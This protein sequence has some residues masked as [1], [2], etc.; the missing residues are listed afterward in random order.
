MYRA[1]L[2]VATAFVI[3][4]STT[5]ADVHRRTVSTTFSGSVTIQTGS[6]C[7]SNGIEVFVRGGSKRVNAVICQ[8]KI[9]SNKTERTFLNLTITRIQDGMKFLGCSK[10]GSESAEY[11]IHWWDTETTYWPKYIYSSQDVLIRDKYY[12]RNGHTRKYVTMKTVGR[13][14]QELVV[15]EPGGNGFVPSYGE[16]VSSNYQQPYSPDAV[17]GCG[18]A[19]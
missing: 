8:L 4:P 2:G 17:D 10:N 19:P 15:V 9:N 3:L 1:V 6:Q 18:P 14:R 13:D 5:N 16:V 7:N 11:R 12:V